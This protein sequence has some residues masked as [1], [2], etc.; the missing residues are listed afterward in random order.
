MIFLIDFYIATWLRQWLGKV[1]LNIL[2]R[3]YIVCHTVHEQQIHCLS[4]Y[5]LLVL[6]LKT[7]IQI[8]QWYCL[9]VFIIQRFYQKSSNM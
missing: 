2:G 3:M 4:M 7:F 1:E 9:A 5:C 8:A 6:Y